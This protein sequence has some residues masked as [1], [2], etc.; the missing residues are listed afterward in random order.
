MRSQEEELIYSNFRNRLK[1][2]K[3]PMTKHIKLEILG[4]NGHPQ[5][6]IYLIKVVFIDN[7]KLSVYMTGQKN[8]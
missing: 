8:V 4:F 1:E 6:L 2:K 3:L 5:N 7:K